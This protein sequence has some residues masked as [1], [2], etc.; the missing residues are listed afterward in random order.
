MI[1]LVRRLNF[2]LSDLFSEPLPPRSHCR[3]DR[4]LHLKRSA[5]NNEGDPQTAS[6]A[7]YLVRQKGL[8]PKNGGLSEDVLLRS[9]HA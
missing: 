2:P 4:K 1:K 3:L 9:K 8:R 5:M 7:R 6:T